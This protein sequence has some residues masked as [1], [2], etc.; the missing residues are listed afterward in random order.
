MFNFLG[1]VEPLH[2]WRGYSGYWYPHSVYPISEVHWL[3]GWSVN[4]I[5]ARARADGYYDPLYIGQSGDFSERMS[6]HEKLVPALL[7][8][9]TH[10]HVHLLAR[11][12]KH[13]LDIETDLRTQF[14]TPL[15]K[16]P[17]PTYRIL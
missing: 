5:L 13:R 8:G 11:D 7:L 3:L 4:Y 10:C 16:Q 15:N 6:K 17:S 2:G 1:G 9:A 14:A 12:K